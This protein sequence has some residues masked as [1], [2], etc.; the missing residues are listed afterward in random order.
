MR[1]WAAAGRFLPPGADETGIGV[2]V[3]LLAVGYVS[4][5]RFFVTRKERFARDIGM[6]SARQIR[7]TLNPREPPQTQNPRVSFASQISREP[8]PGENLTGMNRILGNGG[9]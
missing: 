8:D 5:K 2:L 7:F 6:V 9:A 4:P 3:I 1:A